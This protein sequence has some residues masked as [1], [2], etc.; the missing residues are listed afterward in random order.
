MEL[1]IYLWQTK[2]GTVLN[3]TDMTISHIENC[4][5]FIQNKIDKYEISRNHSYEKYLLFYKDRYEDL[6]EP[7]L[8]GEYLWTLKYG[9]PYLDK[10]NEELKNR[11][12]K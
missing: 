10:F 11:R 4:I 8:N 12:E 1:S 7:E 5:K 9:Y 2:D 6:P 3:I